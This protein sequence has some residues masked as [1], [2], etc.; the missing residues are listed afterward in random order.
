MRKSQQLQ[1]NLKLRAADGRTIERVTYLTV[2]V[3]APLKSQ[4][5]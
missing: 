3:L 5:N 4:A 1:L 2:P